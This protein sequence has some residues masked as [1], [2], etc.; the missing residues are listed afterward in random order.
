VSYHHRLWAC[1]YFRWDERRKIHC[2]GGC[3]LSFPDGPALREYIDRHCAS[4]SGYPSC[5]VAEMRAKY[6]ERT[7]EK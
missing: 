3:V 2:E 1:P 5:T 4:V 7:E 6:Y